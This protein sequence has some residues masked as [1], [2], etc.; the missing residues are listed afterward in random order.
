MYAEP[1][2]ILQTALICASPWTAWISLAAW[3]ASMGSFSR[4]TRVVQPANAETRVQALPAKN[5]KNVNWLK[6]AAG[7]IIVLQYQLVSTFF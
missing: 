1:E 3:D 2:T 4:K 6:L 5:S 7:T